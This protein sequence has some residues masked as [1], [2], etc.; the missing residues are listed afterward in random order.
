MNGACPCECPAKTNPGVLTRRYFNS[1]CQSSMTAKGARADCSTGIA[2]RNRFPS[3]V[4]SPGTEAERRP[5]QGAGSTGV[6]FRTGGNL[7]QHN[8]SIATH[9]KALPGIA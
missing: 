3:A 1:D 2:N 6:E 8:P 7:P 9:A 4:T 5:E